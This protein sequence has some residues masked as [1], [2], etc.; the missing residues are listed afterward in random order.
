MI[1]SRTLNP[2][3]SVPGRY[4]DCRSRRG[5]SRRLRRIVCAVGLLAAVPVV[6]AQEPDAIPTRWTRVSAPGGPSGDSVRALCLSGDELWIGTDAGL[7]RMVDDRVKSLRPVGGEKPT[8]PVSSIDVDPDSRDVWLGT[9]G[10]GLMRYTAGRLDRFDQFDSGL[11]GDVVFSVRFHQARVWAAT[12]GGL[13]IYDPEKDEWT[14]VRERRAGTG[15]SIVTSLASAGDEILGALWRANVERFALT[16]GVR[17]TLY[18]ANTIGGPHGALALAVSDKYVWLATQR[19]VIGLTRDAEADTSAPTPARQFDL[20]VARLGFPLA[21]AADE[22]HVWLGTEK[23]LFIQP[24]D[25]PPVSYTFAAD[26]DGSRGRLVRRERGEMAE[27]G[28]Y[29]CVPQGIVRSILLGED[30]VWVGTS[31]GLFR[32]R[33]RTPAQAGAEATT[34]TW[35]DSMSVSANPDN[36]RDESI[37]PDAHQSAQ[38]VKGSP[39][40]AIYGPRNRT[41]AIPGAPVGAPLERGRPDLN[42]VLRGL[43]THNRARIE[44]GR[45]PIEPEFVTP[46]YAGYAWSLPEDDLARFAGNPAVFGLIAHID[47]MQLAAEATLVRLEL[48]TLNIAT[49]IMDTSVSLPQSPWVIP[50]QQSVCLSATADPEG[51]TL[52]ARSFL[53]AR[54]LARIIDGAGMKRRTVLDDLALPPR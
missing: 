50:L 39:R 26:A 8:F 30:D 35:T 23:G 19:W 48:P 32:G 22:T 15:E 52:D 43:E 11:A 7:V 31:C 28:R 29:D 9:L 2:C 41:I 17:G 45:P 51:G 42:E 24:I 4:F 54:C 53:A 18:V 34:Q 25:Q 46:G 37:F 5:A 40:V 36:H 21:L 49:R 10:G 13:S 33:R 16:D 38:H 1:S 6:L 27:V 47:D 3:R 12:N 14:L 20:H 44:S